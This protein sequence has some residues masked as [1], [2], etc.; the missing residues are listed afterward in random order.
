M[1]TRT[2]ASWLSSRPRLAHLV[3]VAKGRS[4]VDDV[5][6][7]ARQE[8]RRGLQQLRV[9]LRVRRRDLRTL[10]DSEQGLIKLQ[11]VARKIGGGG[12]DEQ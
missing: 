9:H 2:T 5:V 7:T 11:L 10:T 8:R 3:D 6:R 1:L 12:G 4:G